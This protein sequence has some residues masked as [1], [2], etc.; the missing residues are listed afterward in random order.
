[1]VSLYLSLG[2]AVM[3]CI[4]PVFALAP[5]A[6]I[7]GALSD[8]HASHPWIVVRMTLLQPIC[9]GMAVVALLAMIVGLV[10]R[11]RSRRPTWSATLGAFLGGLA[12][13]AWFLAWDQSFAWIALME[14]LGV[15]NP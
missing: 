12:F 6:G 8:E 2:C 7:A 9:A 4:A 14:G 11:L 5:I 13:I 15:R 3:A 1:M 10:T